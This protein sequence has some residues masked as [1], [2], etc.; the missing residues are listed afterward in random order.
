MRL[1]APTPVA[2]SLFLA[3]PTRV[4]GFS[5]SNTATTTGVP[6]ASAAPCLCMSLRRRCRRP[7]TV[8]HPPSLHL[9]EPTA[10]V[11]CQRWHSGGAAEPPRR[12][13]SKCQR[14]ERWLPNG[15]QRGE[16]HRGWQRGTSFLFQRSVRLSARDTAVRWHSRLSDARYAVRCKVKM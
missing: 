15:A 2:P 7:H 14:V 3:A 12:R 6:I 1:P 16:R 5:H 11:P 9:S 10:V 8:Q 13:I 4:L